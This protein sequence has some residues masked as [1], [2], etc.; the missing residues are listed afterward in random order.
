MDPPWSVEGGEGGSV[1][2]SREEQGGPVGSG[3][4]ETRWSITRR[5]F[6][7][8]RCYPQRDTPFDPR[9][10]GY[11]PPAARVAAVP[12]RYPP[13]APRQK[14]STT[15]AP[16][17]PPPPATPHH[18]RRRPRLRPRSPGRPS[19]G[20]R[21]ADTCGVPPVAHRRARLAVQ[22]KPLAS[23]HALPPST[24][25]EP[26]RRGKKST[27]RRERGGEAGGADASRQSLSAHS[28]HTAVAGRQAGTP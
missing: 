5:F 16:M 22:S 8:G 6:S 17:P 18:P 27:K 14:A 13:R 10:R 11:S 3:R 21:G 25:P 26:G 4:G 20:G 1:S 23:P 28:L 15:K 12:Q 19:G 2:A 9:S 24:S 7:G